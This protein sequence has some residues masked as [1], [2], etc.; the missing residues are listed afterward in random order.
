[1]NVMEIVRTRRSARSFKPDPIPE[2]ALHDM[3]DAARLAH[4]FIWRRSTMG[5]ALAGSVFWIPAEPVKFW[6][7]LMMLFVNL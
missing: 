5:S 4:S 6:V 2:Q 7:F 3:L 1:M